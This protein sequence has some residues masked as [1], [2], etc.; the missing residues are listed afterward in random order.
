M[1]TQTTRL[2]R[3]D[4]RDIRV[5]R[6]ATIQVRTGKGRQN[7]T[8]S[9]PRF[10]IGSHHMNDLT[11][12]D[13]TV[14]KQHLEIEVIDSGY[15]ITDLASSN[16]TFLDT[17]RVNS[18]VVAEPVELTLGDS[19]LRFAPGK[20]EVEIPALDSDCF[21][22]LL[23]RSAVMRELFAQLSSV[24]Q[25]E[26]PVLLEG[27]TGVGKDLAAEAI[28]L[29]SRRGEGPFAAV[30][31]GALA[32]SLLE[33][34]LFG[35]VRGALPG[36]IEGGMGILR[37]ADGGT[38]F[39]DKV[40]ELPLTLQPKLLAVLERHVVRPAGSNSTHPVNVRVIAATN[41]NLARAINEGAF[42]SDL[43]YRLAVA[44]LRVPALRERPEDIPLL[45][46]HFLASM[47]ERWESLGSLAAVGG[48]A[49]PACGTALARV[50][51]KSCAVPSSVQSSSLESKVWS[52][53]RWTLLP[54][55]TESLQS[56]SAVM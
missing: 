45:V 3:R 52:A 20:G 10:R 51:F 47:R 55:D 46:E 19:R 30:D 38:V 49:G 21:G 31:C 23:G 40:G 37:G 22:P 18:I 26:S 2:V 6:T 34:E 56:L 41:D 44:V 15:R 48:D 35:H 27:E 24:A 53:L 12:D 11:V 4:E 16:G 5:I 1:A 50:T 7:A 54:S 39:L 36:S 14:S 8:L 29:A 13:P 33:S 28:H 9:A 42:R 43:Y 25:S 17:I 32:G